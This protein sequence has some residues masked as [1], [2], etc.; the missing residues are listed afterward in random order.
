MR[1]YLGALVLVAALA[2]P[3]VALAASLNPSQIG[4]GC[5]EDEIG[6]YHFVNNQVSPDFAAGGKLSVTFDGVTTNNISPYMVL[7]SVQHFS[8]S[9]AGT[10]EAAS[11][12]LS[13]RLVLSDFDCKKKD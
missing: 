11:T 6:T 4:S 12:N 2:L 9:S 10:L 7:K 1:K 5:D 3:A 8:V 13:G